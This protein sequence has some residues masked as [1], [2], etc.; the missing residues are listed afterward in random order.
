M[1]A[2]TFAPSGSLR[3]LRIASLH[4]TDCRTFCQQVN[5]ALDEAGFDAWLETVCRPYLIGGDNHSPIS[6]GMYFRMTLAAYLNENGYP[7]HT[8]PGRGT[9]IESSESL[10]LGKA[11]SSRDGKAPGCVSFRFPLDVHRKVFERALEI[12][13]ARGLLRDSR[14]AGV[15]HKETGDDWTARATRLNSQGE[16]DGRNVGI[17]PLGG[18]ASSMTFDSAHGTRNSA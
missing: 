2:N 9:L 8:P 6:L 17:P 1:V 18:K 12:V 11:I 14:S 3:A 13:A 5:D 15:V 4:K 10:G 16:G 7:I